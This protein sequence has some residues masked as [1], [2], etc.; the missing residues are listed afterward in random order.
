MASIEKANFL[1]TSALS[2]SALVPAQLCVLK[3]GMIRYR[4]TL[5][6]IMTY[7]RESDKVLIRALIFRKQLTNIYLCIHHWLPLSHSLS[8]RTSRKSLAGNRPRAMSA[9]QTL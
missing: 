9:A 3:G 4:M 2:C 1:L 8:L 7:C 5:L 6:V